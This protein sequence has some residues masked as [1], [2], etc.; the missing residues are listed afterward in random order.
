MELFLV[1]W[2]ETW[3]TALDQA[4][5]GAWVVLVGVEPEDLPLEGVE[6]RLGVSTVADLVPLVLEDSSVVR[7]KGL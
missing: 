6:T 4:L 3:E 2:T 1:V 7:Q 5:A